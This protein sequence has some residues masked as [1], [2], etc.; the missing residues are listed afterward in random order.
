MLSWK[1]VHLLRGRKMQNR[2][3]GLLSGKGIVLG[4]RRKE[5]PLSGKWVPPLR[6]KG[7]AQEHLVAEKGGGGYLGS[8]KFLQGGGKPRN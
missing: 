4:A 2:G 3:E 1:R 5:L 6:L 8:S 7:L